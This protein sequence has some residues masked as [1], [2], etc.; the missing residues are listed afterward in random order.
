M[1]ELENKLK[2]LEAIKE[3]CDREEK[4]RMEMRKEMKRSMDEKRWKKEE[5]L[6]LKKKLEEKWAMMR[7]IVN[8]IDEN[9]EQ[10]TVDKE[11]RQSENAGEILLGVK[12]MSENESKKDAENWSENERDRFKK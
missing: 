9:K 7:W 5:R 12:R 3:K 8:Y 2:D 1:T 6:K 4:E 11:I 10:W